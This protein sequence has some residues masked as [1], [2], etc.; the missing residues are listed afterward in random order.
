M[1]AMDDVRCSIAG[2]L[3]EIGERWSL[4]IIR[5]AVMGSS[6]FD[7]F[8]QRTGVARNILNERLQTLV[9]HGIFVRKVSPGNA[10]IFHYT[11]TEKG[12]ELWPVLVALMQWG[13]RWV[14]GK[15]GAP[16]ILRHRST[17][18]QLA[19]LVLTTQT[20]KAIDASEIDIT[21]GPGATRRVR[22]RL[23]PLH[24]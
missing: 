8:H 16:I 15:I 18:E 24:Q 23:T 20:G 21:P 6:R 19:P 3:G 14:H 2:A 9:D 13:D 5:E 7:E 11:L 12:L 1:P 4:L 17:G 22:E 10:R